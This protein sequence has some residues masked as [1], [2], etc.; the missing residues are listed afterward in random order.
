MESVNQL[1][2]HNCILVLSVKR[3]E[4]PDAHFETSMFNVLQP[5]KNASKTGHNRDNA[6]FTY[7]EFSMGAIVRFLIT[8]KQLKSKFVLNNASV[9]YL[10]VND[11]NLMKCY[12]EDAEIINSSYFRQFRL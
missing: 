3:Q 7:E 8:N 1:A 5:S 2:Y 4:L 10:R 11:V 12:I 6:Q 9:F